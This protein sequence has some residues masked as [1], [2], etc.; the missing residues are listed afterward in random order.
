MNIY[1]GNLA[2][3]VSEEE[4]RQ[5]FAAFGQVASVSLIKDKFTGES[6]GFGFVEMPVKTE[7]DA[8][9]Q[10]LNGSD[11]K[12]RSLTVSEARPK[13][14][15]TGAGGGGGR[16]RAGG[17]GGYRGAGGGRGGNRHSY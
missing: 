2:S 13:R 6:R 15:R 17:G 7:A 5:A 16:P 9:L 1:A 3:D 14:E 10:A 11:F 12:G 8:A 4:L